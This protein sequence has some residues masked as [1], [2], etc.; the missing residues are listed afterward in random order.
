MLKEIN[1]ENET[2]L[3][4]PVLGLGEPCNIPVIAINRSDGA[5]IQ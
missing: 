3:T 5:N 4:L 1:K 2:I